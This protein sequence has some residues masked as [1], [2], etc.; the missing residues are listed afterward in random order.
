MTQ[1]RSSSMIHRRSRARFARSAAS[2][3]DAQRARRARAPAASSLSPVAPTRAHAEDEA[4]R[5]GTCC[6]GSLAAA[7]SRSARRIAP[8]S[9]LAAAKTLARP[10][11]AHTRKHARNRRGRVRLRAS[12]GDRA[13]MSVASWSTRRLAVCLAGIVRRTA[14]THTDS[15]AR[16]GRGRLARRAIPHTARE[17]DCPPRRRARQPPSPRR[18]RRWAEKLARN[19]GKR[20]QCA[21][22]RKPRP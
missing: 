16:R 3:G 4:P 10:M 6:F 8:G 1:R 7:G 11:A 17:R 22:R 20:P 2:T 12:R 14:R 19:R 5:R 18:A 13:S 21:T 15:S 9:H